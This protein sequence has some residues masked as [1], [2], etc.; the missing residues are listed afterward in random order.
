MFTGDFI[1]DKYDHRPSLPFVRRFIAGLVA[2]HGMFGI[3]GNH[4]PDVLLAHVA[5]AGIRVVT[6]RQVIVPVRGGQVEIIGLPGPSRYD[7]DLGFVKALPPR[8]MGRPRIVLCHYPDLFFATDQLDPDLYL[9]GHTHGGQICL[10][11]G[12]PII[13]H[14]RMPRSLAKGIHRVNS[15]WYAV[16]NGLG[17]TGLPIRLFCPAEAVEFVLRGE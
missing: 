6:D 7:L 9:A 8:E 11:S 1:N 17:F 16:S 12:Y 3:L 13:T 14:D 4:D 10:P 15:T 5:A 2:K